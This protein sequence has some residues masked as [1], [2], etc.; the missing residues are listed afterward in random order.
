MAN[1]RVNVN[2]LTPTMFAMPNCNR[3]ANT[4]SHEKGPKP[5]RSLQISPYCAWKQTVDLIF[6]GSIFFFVIETNNNNSIAEHLPLETKTATESNKKA[7]QD[8]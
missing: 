3:I 6:A 7:I 2:T 4:K 5:M 8:A 1:K